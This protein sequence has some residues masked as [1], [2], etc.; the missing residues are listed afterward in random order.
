MTEREKRTERSDGLTRGQMLFCIMSALAMLI[1]F[2]LSDVAIEAMSEGMRICVS[3][4]IPSLFPFMVFSEL[5]ISSGAAELVGRYLG[6]VPAKIFGLSK[7]GSAALI[8]GFL[9][10]FPIGSRS[11]ISLY[12]RGRICKG[13]L[14]HILSF[15]NNPSSAFLISAVGVSLFGSQRLGIMLYAAHMFS[16]CIIGAFG[17]VYFKKEKRKNEYYV[18]SKGSG[19]DREGFVSAFTGA[20]SGSAGSVLII[21]AFVIF[22]SALVGYL[23][24]FANIAGLPEY[25]IA[26]LF[27]FFEMTGGMSAVA[28]LGGESAILLAAALSGWSGLSVA[29][30][31][32]GICKE[33]RFPLKPYFVSKIC[34]ALLNVVFVLV[35]I[36]FFGGEIPIGEGSVSSYLAM[37]DIRLVFVS[38]TIFIGGCFSLK[39]KR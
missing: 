38:M 12:E 8:I 6:I 3:T 1:T 33:H 11:A 14:L 4:V 23:R 20:V 34:C 24:F 32:V 36:R 10:G 35:M 27:G 17:R 13:E 30:Q 39:V 2:L 21:C 31:F 22:F 29:F 28:Q 16:S 26:L 15:C 19:A 5:L 18:L 25:A 9:C 37:P 7:E